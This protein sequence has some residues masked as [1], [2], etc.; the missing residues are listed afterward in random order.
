L[1]LQTPGARAFALNPLKKTSD[2]PESV[3][4]TGF[5]AHIRARGKEAAA[6]KNQ[7]QE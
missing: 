6:S 5:T 4:Q 7:R 2:F 3:R 1:A